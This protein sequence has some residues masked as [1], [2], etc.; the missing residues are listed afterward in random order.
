MKQL[1]S[2]YFDRTASEAQV[3][4]LS[5]LLRSDAAARE[6]YLRI[7]SVHARL[8]SDASVWIK[9]Q[10]HPPPASFAGVE[11]C[12]GCGLHFIAFIAVDFLDA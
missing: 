8:A 7:A 1:V 3:A 4:E 11:Y 10:A 2:R 6:E 5:S 12:T 9:Q